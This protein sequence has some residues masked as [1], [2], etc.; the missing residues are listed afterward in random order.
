VGDLQPIDITDPAAVRLAGV[1]HLEPLPAGGHALHRLPAWTQPQVVDPALAL[2]RAMP[3]GCRLEVVTDAAAIELDVQLTMLQIGSEP[4]PGGRF[5]LVVDG[6]LVDG[7]VTREGTVLAVDMTSGALDLTPGGPATVRFDGMPAGEKLVEVW[8]PNA[9]TV[10]LLAVR[11]D[12]AA[13]AP[14]PTRRRWVHYG[15]SISHCVEADR[16]TGVWPAVA[17]RLAGVDLQSLGLAG[18]CHLDGFVA[19]T[20][21]DLPADVISCKLGINIV[22]GDTMRERTFVPAVH[23]LLDTIR[24]G[25]PDTPLLVVT[26]IFCPPHE[27]GPGPSLFRDGRCTSPA[28]RLGWS[29]RGRLRRLVRG[30]V[31]GMGAPGGSLHLRRIRQLHAE[32]VEAR[33][34][35]GDQHLHLLSGL[36]LF[37]PDD[38][39]DL[40]DDLHPNAAGYRRIGERFAALAFGPGGPFAA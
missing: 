18:Q 38:A 6:E 26:P 5:D 20:I 16:P 31:S 39:A 3:S 19:R 15:S 9:A 24:E 2:M 1:L 28:D 36:E 34:A 12:G 37:G 40:P 30:P 13:R 4:G 17:A 10:D 7:A 32:I 25:H 22:N 21:R 14:E 23:N 27:E 35:A 29:V 8:L 11:L 33:R